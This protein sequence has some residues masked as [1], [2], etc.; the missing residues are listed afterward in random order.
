VYWR[1]RFFPLQHLSTACSTMRYLPAIFAVSAARSALAH[2]GSPHPDAQGRYTI[3]AE[4]IRAQFIPYAATLTNLF[5]KGRIQSR[6]YIASTNTIIDPAGQELDI[7]LGYDNTSY[8]RKI[9]R[10]L[11][12]GSSNT[13][14]P[15]TPDIPSTTQSP[16]AT[17][18]ALAT[19]NI[20]LTT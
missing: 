18:T 17:S 20:P 2:P 9:A 1:G 16:D 4:G 10:S 3:E 15:S 8:Y 13:L 12:P 7:V 11:N 5:V 14:Q 6:C 19:A